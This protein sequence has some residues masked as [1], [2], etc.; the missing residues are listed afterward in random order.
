MGGKTMVSEEEIRDFAE[1]I[2]REFHPEKII[3]FG[4]YA[5]GRPT[6]DS[7][8]DLLVVM[9]HTGKAHHAATAIR[10]R[11]DHRFPL[12]LLVRS[13]AEVASRLEMGDPFVREILAQGAVLYE[14]GYS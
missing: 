6:E 7:D 10:N 9:E 12:D 2:A 13:P 3:L 5:C 14:T 11:L 4:S 1:A 8:V